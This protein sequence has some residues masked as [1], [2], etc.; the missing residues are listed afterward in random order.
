VSQEEAQ[1][2]LVASIVS[3]VSFITL[4]LKKF[5][6]VNKL[7]DNAVKA[8]IALVCRGLNLS[9]YEIASVCVQTTIIIGTQVNVSQSVAFNAVLTNALLRRIEAPAIGKDCEDDHLKN[10]KQDASSLLMAICMDAVVDMH[11][12]D[13][14]AILQN[15]IKLDASKRLETAFLSIM[16][17]MQE[18]EKESIEKQNEAQLLE[19]CDNTKDFI[20]YKRQ[21]CR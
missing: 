11:S 6:S 20:E 4:L 9:M 19:I 7:D 2:V 13:D 21:F 5:A 16:G 15:F 14:A 8:V 3:S 12:S 17:K 1:G 18:I 10:Y